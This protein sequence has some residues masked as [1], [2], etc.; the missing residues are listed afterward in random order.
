[1]TAPAELWDS[2]ALPQWLKDLIDSPD[3]WDLLERLDAFCA[4]IREHRG[5][6]IHPTAVLE[7]PVY[8]AGSAEIGPGAY[9]RGPAWVGEN[10]TVGH[11]VF[12]RDGVVLAEGSSVNHASEVKRSVILP[13]AK[14]PHFNYVGDSVI[15]SR[16]NLGAGVKIANFNAFGSGVKTAG[17]VSRVLPKAGALVGD[18]ASIGCNAVLAPGTVIGARTVIYDGANVRGVIPADTV[19]KLRTTLETVSRTY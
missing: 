5:G 10:V 16:V 1:V 19:V 18:D 11:A 3:G 14:V 8:V 12:L 9:I 13:G 7:G 6:S 2:A 17:A 15:G 4:R